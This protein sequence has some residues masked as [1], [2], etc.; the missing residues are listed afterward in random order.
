MNIEDWKQAGHI[1]HEALKYGST[2]IKVNAR[3]SDVSDAIEAK[4]KELKG[5]LAFPVNIS[6]NE[7]AAHQVPFAVDDRVFTENDLIKLDVGVHVNGA[8]GDNALTRDLT[9]KYEKLIEASIEARD[10]AI[11][12]IKPGIKTSEIGKVIEKIITK[13]GFKPVRNLS[14]H[15]IK[16]YEIH[17]GFTIPNYDDKKNTV[18]KEGMIIAVEPFATDGEGLIHESSNAEIFT[19]LEKKPVRSLITREALKHLEERKGLPTSTRWLAKKM[20]AIKATF[21]LKEMNQLNML[22]LYP[23][24]IEIKKGMVAQSEH[25]VL[26]TKD[27]H[28]ILTK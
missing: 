17:A 8:I 20:S 6:L 16:E 19:L 21:A 4:I 3:I 15:Q 22:H 18:L 10:E 25:T 14:G 24:L 13:H 23:P 11:K 9:K 1:A 26:V 28:E 2:L 5:E 12:M 27:G 7:A